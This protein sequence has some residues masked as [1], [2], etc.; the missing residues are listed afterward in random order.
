M[1]LRGLGSLRGYGAARLATA[2]GMGASIAGLSVRV[3]IVSREAVRGSGVHSDDAADREYTVG[4]GRCDGRARSRGSLGSIERRRGG[5][6]RSKR[7]QRRRLLC[8][9]PHG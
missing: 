5:C 1:G 7:G 4:S 8:G 2:V 3:E 6:M 9:C